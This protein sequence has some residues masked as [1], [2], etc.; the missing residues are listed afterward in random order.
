MSKL[1]IYTILFLLSGLLIVSACG[2][3]QK[4]EPL[5][6]Q[7]ALHFS[8]IGHIVVQAT[9]KALSSQLQKAVK[10]QGTANAVAYCNTVAIAI[11]DSMS[12]VKQAQVRRTSLKLRNPNNNPSAWELEQL[13]LYKS[14]LAE[15][16]SLSPVVK[17]L[18][19]GTIIYME[20]ILTMPFCLQC[21]G[22]PADDVAQKLKELYPEDKAIG[23]KEGD[24][25]GIWTV[26][27]R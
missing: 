15:G 8:E 5:T 26:K 3:T 6:K 27:L 13:K 20:P 2:G 16:R 10:E 22:Q 23:Y 25:R 1:T 11:T 12:T 4:T 19:N 7:D 14:E 18:E 21:H 17:R 9:F 24:L